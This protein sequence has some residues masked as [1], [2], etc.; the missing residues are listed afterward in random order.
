MKT[1]DHDIA[2]IKLKEKAYVYNNNNIWPVCLPPPHIDLDGKRAYVAG[3]IEKIQKTIC[4]VFST[5]SVVSTFIVGWGKTSFGGLPSDV[6]LDVNL[7]IW[8]KEECER[9]FQ[10]R[11]DPIDYEFQFCAGPK[12]GGEDACDVKFHFFFLYMNIKYN[13]NQTFIKIK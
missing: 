7:P 10:I 1:F 2:L 3:Y 9:V 13:L 12:D 6:L 8:E 11:R 4:F 5:G